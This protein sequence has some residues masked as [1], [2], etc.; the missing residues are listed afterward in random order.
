MDAPPKLDKLDLDILAG[1][2]DDA[3]VS[4]PAL[5]AKIGSN[6]SVTYAR[7]R[8]LVKNG[9]IKRYT[10]II[11]EKGLGYGVKAR[12]GL[13]I[14]VSKREQIIDQMLSTDGISEVSEMTGRFDVIVTAHAKSL[15]DMHILVSEKIGK[16]DGVVSSETFIEMKT[17]TRHM[18]HSIKGGK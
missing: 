13:R 16:I 10:I 7:V 6:V 2:A 15:D 4:I 1:L 3:S 17:A 5:A 8:R 14:E 9:T 11:N 18:P 12:V